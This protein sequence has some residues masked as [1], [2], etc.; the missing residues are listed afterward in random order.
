[1]SVTILPYAITSLAKVKLALGITDTSQDDFLTMMINNVTSF[2]EN[3]CGGRRFLATDYVEVHDTYHSHNIFF[4]Q[5][6]VISV[7]A[8][9][10]RTGVPSTPVWITYDPNVYLLYL[11]PGYVRFFS[12]FYPAPQAIRLSYNAGYLIDF[13][14]ETDPTMHTLPFDLTNVATDIVTKKFNTK[15]VQGISSQ[16]TE[17]QSVTFDARDLDDINKTALNSYRINRAAV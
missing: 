14:H 8:I 16:T 4:N 5:R 15:D 7:A 17:G 1:M 6:P 11:A 2:I 3:Y 12:K 9:A 13:V 10:Y